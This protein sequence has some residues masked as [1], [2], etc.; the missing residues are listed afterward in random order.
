MDA[1]MSRVRILSY[2]YWRLALF[3]NAALF[4]GAAGANPLDRTLSNGMKVIV[5]EDHRAPVVV[6]MVWYRAGSIDEVNGKTGVAHVLEHM[7]FKGTKEVP[8]GEFSRQVARA[9]GRDNAFT[10]RDHTAYFQQ[11]QKSQLPL[12]L[13]LEADRMAN[14]VLSDEEFAKEIRV[15]MEERRLRTDDQ[16]QARL[17]EQIMA[18]VYVAHPYRTPIIG[19]MNDLENMTAEDA[20]E[21]Y[22]RWYAPNNA[23]LVVV[24]DVKTEEVF[25]LAQ[26]KF[27]GIARRPLAARKPQKEPAQIGTRRITVKV[28]AE[29]PRLVMAYQ[30]PS[31]RDVKQ[32]WE[33][34]ALAVLSGV[35]DGHDAARLEKN[36]VRETKAALS[37]GASYNGVNRG[38]ALFFLDGTPAPGKSVL[39]LEAALREEIRKIAEDGVSEQ[40]LKRVKAQVVASQV[41]QLD[42]MFNQAR[43]MGALEISELPYDSAREQGERLLAITSAQ[44]SAV[45]KKYLTDDNLTVAVL[46]PL[47]VQD[48]KPAAVP[49]SLR[50]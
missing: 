17:F 43:L 33:P 28:P 9:G 50:H 26:E 4:L 5:K 10:S 31:L 20:R 49:P 39:T 45:A 12:A 44:V 3:A 38:E 34:Y 40:E 15:V 16:P 14:L 32:D 42:S 30:A 11:L 8:P 36:L 23:V 41:Y 7:M 48:R 2:R 19:W 46:D 47:P 1:T 35:L 22:R 27:G 29:L 21:W 18:A 13:K 37:A 6:S 24:G 25:T